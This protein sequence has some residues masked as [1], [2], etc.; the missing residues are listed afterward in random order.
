MLFEKNVPHLDFS[1][2]SKA[3]SKVVF[4]HVRTDVKTIASCYCKAALGGGKSFVCH[5]YNIT[6][7]GKG[8][9][10]Q[11]GKE[12]AASDLLHA[13]STSEQNFRTSYYPN[14][15]GLLS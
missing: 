6:D 10:A 3:K 5:L 11:P 14:R 1:L 15:G 9:Q 8:T 13:E 2:L 4:C 12:Y 7:L